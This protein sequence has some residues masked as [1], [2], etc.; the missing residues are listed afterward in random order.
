M[1]YL[2]AQGKNVSSR[3]LAK[4]KQSIPKKAVLKNVPVNSNILSS[5]NSKERKVVQPIYEDQNYAIQDDLDNN[6]YSFQDPAP[7]IQNSYLQQSYEPPERKE[8]PL[9]PTICKICK[10]RSKALPAPNMCSLC[11]ARKQQI[12][13]KKAA[14]QRKLEED[15]AYLQE[16]IQKDARV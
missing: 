16:I 7:P 4:P 8:I 3:S 13:E 9:D 14:D 2:R 12:E 5:Q 10:R 15:A 1:S 11:L 6:K